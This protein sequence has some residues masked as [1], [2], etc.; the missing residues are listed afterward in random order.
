MESN[1]LLKRVWGEATVS[2]AQGFSLSSNAAEVEDIQHR[3]H[4]DNTHS[5]SLSNCVEM[6]KSLVE[7]K[8]RILSPSSW[9]MM[10]PRKS[11]DE[12]KLGKL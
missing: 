4:M 1:C 10:I 7:G 8:V 12:P 11:G 6:R 2:F 5:G 9:E 3:G